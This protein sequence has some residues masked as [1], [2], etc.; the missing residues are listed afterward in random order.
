MKKKI[1][2]IISIILIII[3]LIPNEEKEMR[4]RVLANSNSEEDQTIKKEVVDILIKEINTYDKDSLS[5]EIK[6]NKETIEMKINT[7]LKKHESEAKVEIKKVSFPP[8]EYQEKVISGG[9]Y[10]TLL[11]TIGK[12][13]GKNYWSM[14]YPDYFN[15][16]YEDF[17]SEEIEIKSFFW[18]IFN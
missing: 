8:K 11:V 5:S 1:I 17:K 9:T 18:E 16:S 2:L 7:Y 4:I 3:L 15:V 10:L 6:E 13:E 14:L 12:G